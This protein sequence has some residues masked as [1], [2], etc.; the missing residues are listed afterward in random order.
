MT[1]NLTQ[2]RLKELLHYEPETG[3]FT[4][5]VST[6]NQV[7]AGAVAGG[8]KLNGYV[9]ITIDGKGYLAHRLAWFY[10]EGYF[11]EHDVDHVNRIRDDNRRINLREASRSCNLKNAGDR[12][13]NSSGVKGI[14]F[15][16]RAN[17]FQAQIVINWRCHYLGRYETLL[18]AACARYAA[19]QCL[20]WNDCDSNS[21]AYQYL[22]NKGVIK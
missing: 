3:I 7:K 22:K 17:K 2:A 19:E 11:P 1:T 20:N 16:K 8:L 18:E 21:S 9:Q 13:T 10:T 5:R 15:Y 4:R 12:S 6:G 14:T